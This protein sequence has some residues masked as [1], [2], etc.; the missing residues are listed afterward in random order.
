MFAIKAEV[1]DPSAQT[2]PAA[3]YS[4]LSLPLV[5]VPSLCGERSAGDAPVL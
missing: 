1:G 4:Q 3:F 2:R 5:A